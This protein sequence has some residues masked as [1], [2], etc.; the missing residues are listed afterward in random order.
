MDDEEAA[1]SATGLV[2]WKCDQ[3]AY[4][5]WRPADREPWLCVICGYERWQAVAEAVA[6]D[7]PD[8]PEEA[9]E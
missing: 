4:H 7:E 8:E 2:L 5:E 9:P 1:V 6:P 3:C